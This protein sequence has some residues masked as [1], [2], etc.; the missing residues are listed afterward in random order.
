MDAHKNNLKIKCVLIFLCLFRR[1]SRNVY[2]TLPKTFI[3]QV[4]CDD[5]DSNKNDF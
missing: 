3:V 2:P 4:V 1:N 5:G